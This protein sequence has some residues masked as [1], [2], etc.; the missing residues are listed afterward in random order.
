M[1][2]TIGKHILDSNHRVASFGS[3]LCAVVESFFNRWDVLI[4]NVVT[5]SGVFKHAG[6]VSV[7]VIN[8]VIDRLNV[9]DDLGVLASTTTLLL[10]QIVELC[11]GADRLSVVDSRVSN[12]EVNVV[13]SLHALAVD[14][15]MQF[16]HAADDDLL[17]FFVLVYYESWVLSL[18][19]IK[20][21]QE[22]V[23]LVLFLWFDSE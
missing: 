10:V 22:E 13:F 23:K 14:K 5:C 15:Q 16:A 6:K 2:S 7:G 12:D 3:F 17:A 4:G 18:E 21:L 19:P 11:L 9:S 1:S 8:L 20:R